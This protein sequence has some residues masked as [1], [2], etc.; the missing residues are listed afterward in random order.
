MATFLGSSDALCISISMSR[1]SSRT[2]ASREN[3]PAETSSIE[4]LQDVHIH[5]YTSIRHLQE[6]VGSQSTELLAGRSNQQYLIF[7]GVTKGGLA[8]IDRK[9][10]SI[11]KHTR[12]TYDAGADLLIVK[13][14]PSVEHEST[15]LLLAYYLNRALE[16]MGL[17]LQP[18]FPLGGTKFSGPNSSK[19]G[20][21]AYKPN[22]RD[23]RTDW[24]TIVFESGL[25]KGLTRLRHDARW[26]LTNSGGDVKIVIIISVTPAEKIL[27]VEKWCLS[28]ATGNR[29]AATAPPNPNYLVPTRMQEITITQYPATPP[30]LTAQ[31]S[32]TAQPTAAK[33]IAYLLEQ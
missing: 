10:G 11:G 33:G 18:L 5:Q 23:K 12:I 25:S 14:M 32:T 7:R 19:E 15:H 1:S 29:P 3:T 20:D 16:T 21:S 9:R 27:Q 2:S 24:P 28:P 26:W 31:P 13:L 4:G 17:P 6:R 8:E 22:S 30:N